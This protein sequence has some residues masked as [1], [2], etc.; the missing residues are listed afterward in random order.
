LTQT[1]CGTSRTIRAIPGRSR[2]AAS[3][4]II[5]VKRAAPRLVGTDAINNL[6]R[7][8]QQ[9]CCNNTLLTLN[10][11]THIALLISPPRLRSQFDG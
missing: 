8:S 10:V 3:W 11:T 7:L 6:A 9:L 5:L 4:Q 2:S 1:R